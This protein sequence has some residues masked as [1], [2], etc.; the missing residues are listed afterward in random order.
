MKEA[1]RN[2]T[3]TVPS[4]LLGFYYDLPISESKCNGHLERRVRETHS[5]QW[6]TTVWEYTVD[7]RDLNSPLCWAFG[8]GKA[9]PW[10]SSQADGWF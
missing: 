9:L 6:L 10:G 3:G 1:D 4:S 8:V 5:A 7:V 2:L